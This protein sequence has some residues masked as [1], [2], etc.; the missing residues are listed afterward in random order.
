[1]VVAVTAFGLAIS[2]DTA[3]L[4]THIGVGQCLEVISSVIH[5]AQNIEQCN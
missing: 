3:C 2:E 5:H 4:A 1:M